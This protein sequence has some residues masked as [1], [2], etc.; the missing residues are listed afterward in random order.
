MPYV[1]LIHQGIFSK[2]A[3]K[4]WKIATGVYYYL[5]LFKSIQHNFSPVFGFLQFD[6]STVT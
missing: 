3:R 5:L 6:T 4:T 2:S 1:S